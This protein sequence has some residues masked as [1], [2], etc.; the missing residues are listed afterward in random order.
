MSANGP[1]STSEKTTAIWECRLKTQ[2]DWTSFGA[3][4]AKHCQVTDKDEPLSHS[5]V[6]SKRK[7]FFRKNVTVGQ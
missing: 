5:P 4:A 2:L 3:T 7:I 6:I 1:V